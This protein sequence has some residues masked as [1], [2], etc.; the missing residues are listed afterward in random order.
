MTTVE[1]RCLDMPLARV[2]VTDGGYRTVAEGTGVVIHDA[3]SGLYEVSARAAGSTSA[4]LVKV[5]A[6]HAKLVDLPLSRPISAAPDGRTPTHLEITIRASAALARQAPQAAGLLIV[7]RRPGD[8]SDPFAGRVRWP[9]FRLRLAGGKRADQLAWQRTP[10]DGDDIA[11]WAGEVPPGGHILTTG[12]PLDPALRV[13][14]WPQW[15]TVVFVPLADD[16]PAPALTVM[17]CVRGSAGWSDDRLADLTTQLHFALDATAE[18]DATGVSR[19]AATLDESLGGG[20]TPPLTALLLAHV[21]VLAGDRATAR[22]HLDALAAHDRPTPVVAAD[23]AALDLLTADGRSPSDVTVGEVPI[24]ARSADVLLE[25]EARHLGSIVGPAAAAYPGRLASTLWFRW[26]ARAEAVLGPEVASRRD[27]R[28]WEAALAVLGAWQLSLDDLERRLGDERNDLATTRL[29]RR[30]VDAAYVHGRRPAELFA[31][32]AELVRGTGLPAIALAQAAQTVEYPRR[33]SSTRRWLR[34]GGAGALAV[35]AAGATWWWFDDDG[36]NTAPDA[37]DDV[38][39]AA[40]NGTAVVDVLAN[41]SDG[42]GDVLSIESV[43]QPAHGTAEVVDGRVQ[44]VS[45]DTPVIDDRFTYVV[46]DG[47]GG[48]ATGTVLVVAD[49][50]STTISQATSTTRSS[51]TAAVNRN[52]VATADEQTVTE[53]MAATIDVLANDRDDDGDELE[54]ISVTGEPANGTAQVVD[55]SI[56][57]TPAP[58]FVGT[59]TFSYALGDGR[60]GLASGTVTVFVDGAPDAPVAIGDAFTV[61]E[62]QPR[63]LDLIANDTDADGDQLAILRISEP[64]TGTYEQIDDRTVQYLASGGSRADRFAYVAT[65]GAL[66]SQPATVE[67]TVRPGLV[68]ED[69]VVNEGEVNAISISLSSPAP[70]AIRGTYRTTDGT[71]GSPAD[72]VAGIGTFEFPPGVGTT[73]LDGLEIVDDQVA[74]DD[75]QFTIELTVEHPGGFVDTATIIV[76]IDDD[77]VE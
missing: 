58:D 25:H 62:G 14:V 77:I 21:A 54:L 69:P 59:D 50:V 47:R 1:V 41:D 35:A 53:D 67:V 26:S 51:T 74:E 68:A 28:R 33:R 49:D 27:G 61:L 37:R 19:F 71:A 4:R 70:D 23:L 30:V 46:V 52:P 44:Y 22:R 6:S 8:G 31:D 13:P 17:H 72:Y 73:E 40:A 3:P 10:G 63:L 56:E 9:T 55:D 7:T 60:G 76:T 18:L 45:N 34:W 66:E 36:G 38:V 65:D 64:V 48:R 42:D 20:R 15:Q 16:G 5:D 39:T 75:E 43:E 2:T 32:P 12:G 29:L 24:L 57:Y 11:V